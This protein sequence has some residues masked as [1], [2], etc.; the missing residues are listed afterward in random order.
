MAILMA[1]QQRQETA[2]S[3]AD[4]LEVSR[5]T[6][7]RDMQSLS[8]IGVPLYAVSG[9]AGGYRLMEGYAFPPLQLDA[10]EALAVLFALQAT[11]KLT[12]SPFNR[13][14]WTA[15]DKLRAAMPARTLTEI[16]PLL[17]QVE[18][19][20]PERR[21]SAPHLDALIRYA[22]A[23]EWIRGQYRSERRRSELILHPKRVYTAHG[24]WYCEAYSAGH[25]EVRTFRA[26][27]FESVAGTAAPAE[28]QTGMAAVAGGGLDVGL[29]REEADNPAPADTRIVAQLT[30]RGALIVE[31]DVHVGELV[32]QLT[33]DVW[34]LDFRCPASEWNWAVRL[35]FTLGMDA[36]VVEPRELRRQLHLMSNQLADRYRPAEGENGLE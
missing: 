31:Q 6:V 2:Q 29:S 3:L 18:L 15:L 13:A 26:D 20:V 1:L 35:F 14:R 19:E 5:R 12:D 21:V 4:K 24:F 16:E 25:G 27:R 22:A 34:E 10:Q 17:R 36:E 30:Y 33:E 8:E 32:R 11:T 7:L 9:P 23:G 28:L